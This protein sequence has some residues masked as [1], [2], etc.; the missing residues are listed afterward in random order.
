MYDLYMNNVKLRNP[1]LIK[2]SFVSKL[3]RNLYGWFGWNMSSTLIM[4]FKKNW[5][6]ILS[7]LWFFFVMK[8]IIIWANTWRTLIAR[9]HNI[10]GN[11]L[12]ANVQ[13]EF[14][15]TWTAIMT[16]ESYYSMKNAHSFRVMLLHCVTLLS[17]YMLAH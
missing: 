4:E 14:V 12:F 8:F 3:K 7:A 13:E 5:K 2:T 6:W 15:D 17:R 11:S 1:S 9:V 16:D 10:F